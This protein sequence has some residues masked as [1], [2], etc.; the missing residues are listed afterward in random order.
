[1]DHFLSSPA[2]FDNLHTTTN[3]CGTVRPD[4]KKKE[5]NEFWTE[6]ENE[7]G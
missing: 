2:S 5:A 6:N 1:M 3:C 7:A 4:K